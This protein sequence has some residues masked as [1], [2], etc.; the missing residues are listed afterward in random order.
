VEGIVPF[1]RELRRSGVRRTAFAKWECG[2]L[3]GL[4]NRPDTDTIS[5]IFTQ[6]GKKGRRDF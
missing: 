3:K 1:W 4:A 2:I 6:K 5:F